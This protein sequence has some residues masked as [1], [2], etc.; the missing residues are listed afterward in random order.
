MHLFAAG[1]FEE[2]LM[3]VYNQ[4]SRQLHEFLLIFF[5]LSQVYHTQKL[6]KILFL[7]AS[8]GSIPLP[9]HR[10]DIGQQLPLNHAVLLPTGLYKHIIFLKELSRE[11]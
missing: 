7:F 10:Y 5:P 1:F 3:W 8:A 6:L 4:S 9:I 2:T 11:I